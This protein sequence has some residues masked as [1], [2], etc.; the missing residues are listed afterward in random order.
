MK[1]FKKINRL[2]EQ[3]TM[4]LE[5]PAQN[6]QPSDKMPAQS[7][8]QMAQTQMPMDIE[9]ALSSI[10]SEELNFDFEKELDGSSEIPSTI[11]NMTVS[12]FIEKSKEI[13]AIVALGLE[14]FILKN[15]NS[16]DFEEEKQDDFS[17]LDNIEFGSE[18]NQ[19]DEFKELEFPVEENPE[20]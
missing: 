4:E 13:D 10:D 2:F 5:V 6:V 8:P 1:N 3:N 17:D 7:P 9:K 12:Q 18:E 16:F 19:E 15:I 11:L 14:S 20:A